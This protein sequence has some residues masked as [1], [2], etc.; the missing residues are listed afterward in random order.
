M[1]S[2]SAMVPPIVTLG[3]RHGLSSMAA[4]Q[5]RASARRT[6]GTRVLFAVGV[7][8]LVAVGEAVR[9]AVVVPEAVGDEAGGTGVAGV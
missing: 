7:R 3:G 6:V 4:F 1:V 8:R 9:R 2:F 5:C